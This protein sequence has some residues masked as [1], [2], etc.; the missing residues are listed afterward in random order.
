MELFFAIPDE[1]I[2]SKLHLQSL[3]LLRLVLDRARMINRK[4]TMAFVAGCIAESFKMDLFIIF[5]SEDNSEKLVICCRVL[6]G[7]DKDNDGL[8]AVEEDVFLCQL[9]NTM[10]SSVSLR[11]VPGIHR[12][13][14][15]EHDI[16]YINNKGSI[17]T[18]KQWVLETDGINLKAVMCIPGMDFMHTYSNSCVE[19]F[20]VLG[21]EAHVRRS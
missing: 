11:G 21:I 2:D 20:N 17:K 16:V 8:R 19:I 18:E 15:L 14:L 12:V 3:W 4:L 5:W 1:E 13:F 9:E 10:L 7:G 6:R